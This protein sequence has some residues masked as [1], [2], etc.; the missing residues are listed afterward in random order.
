MRIAWMAMKY[1]E[2]QAKQPQLKKKI[3]AAPVVKPGAK[4]QSNSPTDQARSR[5]NKSGTVK[6]AAALFRTMLKD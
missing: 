3:A 2:M 1:Q 6:D 4:K 5:F